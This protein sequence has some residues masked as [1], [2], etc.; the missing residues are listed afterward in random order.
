MSECHWQRE[1]LCAST[2][3]LYLSERAV[4]QPLSGPEP[5]AQL[6]L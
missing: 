5:C 3:R 1:V 2:P 4:L 6:G